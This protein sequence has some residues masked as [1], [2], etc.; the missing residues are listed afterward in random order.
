MVL[1]EGGRVQPLFKPTIDD[2][3]EPKRNV[4]GTENLKCVRLDLE[5]CR[6]VI[7]S[8]AAKH[9]NLRVER[10]EV[11]DVRFDLQPKLAKVLRELAL[12]RNSG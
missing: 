9:I 10:T 1:L 5:P 4:K 12:L 6:P 7:R 8:V 11:F 3:R 2:H